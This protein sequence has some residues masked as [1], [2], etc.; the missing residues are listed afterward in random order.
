MNAVIICCNHAP[1]PEPL[2]AV[3]PFCL[4]PVGDKSIIEHMI[5]HCARTGIRSVRLV[6]TD[7]PHLVRERLGS[8]EKWG[9]ELQYTAVKSFEGIGSALAKNAQSLPEKMLLFPGLVMFSPEMK[10]LV[11]EGVKS[12]AQAIFCT[13]SEKGNILD[14]LVLTRELVNSGELK[15]ASSAKAAM[16]CVGAAQGRSLSP[17]G[18]DT[19][20]MHSLEDVYRVNMHA[21]K[22]AP[23]WLLFH[24]VEGLTGEL[25]GP[26]AKTHPQSELVTPVL[27]GE[28]S[29][30]GKAAVVGPSAV[31][32]EGCVVAE[33]A[34]IQ[35]SVVCA[36]GYVGPNTSIENALVYRGMMITFPDQTFIHITD[37]FILG[38]TR[39]D[40]MRDTANALI[41]RIIGAVALLL[42][43][44]LMLPFLVRHFLQPEAGILQR[45]LIA[46]QER[47]EDLAG[48]RE[49]G[50]TTMHSFQLKNGFLAKLP[51]L[52]D[53]LMGRLHL[54]GVE[55]LPIEEAKALREPW[56]LARFSAPPGLIH[57]WNEFSVR[58]EW[59][60]DEKRVMESYYAQTRTLKG[61][62]ALLLKSLRRFCSTG[63][64]S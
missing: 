55:P 30:V 49:L 58:K 50:V 35:N 21:L 12:S 15:N 45:T 32:G 54:V 59:G 24:A 28:A 40:F 38:E 10:T 61:D 22:G 4:L 29:E 63:P 36:G 23:A 60:S 42:F 34:H 33:G 27:L 6:L 56:C 2:A 16:D 39:P 46:G 13:S 41:Q 8:G 7:L 9:V 48:A 47:Q 14:V 18:L 52:Y 26:K 25:R 11:E 53:V 51:A 37:P 20:L 31:L 62:L 3:V 44:P 19:I 57:P 5:E 43:S 17:N 64:T 1:M